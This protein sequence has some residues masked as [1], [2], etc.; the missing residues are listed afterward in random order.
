LTKLERE[1]FEEILSKFCFIS[2]FDEVF[3]FTEFQYETIIRQVLSNYKHKVNVSHFLED[4]K[5]SISLLVEDGSIL[6]FIH[7]SIQEYFA[8]RYVGVL[9][10][11]YKAK[12]LLNLAK[13]QNNRKGNHT[14]LIELISELYQY[15]FKK[16]YIQAHIEEF[17]N[18]KEFYLTE[19]SKLTGYDKVFDS[20]ENFKLILSYSKEFQKIYSDFI[21]INTFTNENINIII[22]ANSPKK[23]KLAEEILTL[24]ENKERLYIQLQAF[25]KNLDDSNKSILEFAFKY[26]S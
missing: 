12:F 1:D 20:F 11:E 3:T 6:S 4:L 23:L 14:F 25:V 15:E 9:N 16:Y 26:P 5:I 10:E 24:Y 21:K 18:N 22:A 7:R 13:V 17:Y 8:A 2:Y 19:H